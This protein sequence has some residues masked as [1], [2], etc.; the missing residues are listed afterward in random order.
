MFIGTVA[1]LAP[2]MLLLWF[3]WLLIEKLSALLLVKKS[4]FSGSI[5]QSD[6][7]SSAKDPQ[8]GAAI[9]QR[10]LYQLS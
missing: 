5:L 4:H 8:R 1:K 2:S 3:F 9:L 10:L 7:F 6:G